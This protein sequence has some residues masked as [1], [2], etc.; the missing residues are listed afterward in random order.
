MWMLGLSSGLIRAGNKLIIGLHVRKKFNVW[1]LVQAINGLRITVMKDEVGFIILHTPTHILLFTSIHRDR[2]RQIPNTWADY[3]EPLPSGIT[4]SLIDNARINYTEVRGNAIPSVEESTS[5]IITICK[6]N[7][8]QVKYSLLLRGVP[9][10]GQTYS[11]A[12]I[13]FR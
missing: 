12:A 6:L 2:I 11:H 4:L 7:N 1:D 9:T 10:A 8:E 3:I 5:V 13:R